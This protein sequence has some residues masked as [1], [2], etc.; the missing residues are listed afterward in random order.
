MPMVSVK[1]KPPPKN[2]THLIRTG[3]SLSWGA[4]SSFSG[5]WYEVPNGGEIPEPEEWLEL[6][7]YEPPLRQ[8]EL[9]LEAK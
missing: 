2:V 7:F 4:L 3:A 5:K 9:N 1:I 6:P 8:A